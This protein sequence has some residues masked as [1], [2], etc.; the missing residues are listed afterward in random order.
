MRFDP[1]TGP[2]LVEDHD[3]ENS[4]NDPANG[5]EPAPFDPELPLQ[6]R[7]LHAL[8]PGLVRRLNRPDEPIVR[9]LVP[10]GAGTQLRPNQVMVLEEVHRTVGDAFGRIGSAEDRAPSASRGDQVAIEP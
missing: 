6:L 4:E 1:T 10:A 2:V 8:T 9:E 7:D 5:G 3:S